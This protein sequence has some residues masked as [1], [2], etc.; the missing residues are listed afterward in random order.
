[1]LFRTGKRLHSQGY[2]KVSVGVRLINFVNGYT[3][4]EVALDPSLSMNVYLQ[5]TLRNVTTHIRLLKRMRHSLSDLA[6]ESVYKA[7]FL[8]KISLCS[9]PVLKVSDTIANQFERIQ[10]SAIKIIHNQS[11]SC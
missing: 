8:P 3:Y 5:K 2:S 1:M 6:A 4:L 9:N 11:K 7:M 10:K